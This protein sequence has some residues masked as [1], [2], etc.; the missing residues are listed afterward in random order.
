MFRNLATY[1]GHHFQSLHSTVNTRFVVCLSSLDQKKE[2]NDAEKKKDVYRE[3]ASVEDGVK[4]RKH[5][6][7][8]DGS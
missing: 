6:R 3:I 7:W 8:Q 2:W 1:T 4:E 5:E